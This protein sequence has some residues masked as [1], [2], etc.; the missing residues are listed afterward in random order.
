[1]NRN[2]LLRWM[3]AAC[4]TL[5][6][7]GA[8]ASLTYTCDSTIDA[9][10]AGT[11]AAL[12][13]SI[14]GLYNSTFTNANASIYIQYGTTGLGSSTSGFLNLVS[15]NTYR[16]ALAST[17][18]GNA[19]DTSALA[20]LPGAEPG[21]F[22]G[23]Q[24]Q[25][26]SALGAAL[27]LSGM[28]GT[29]AGGAACFTPG[30]GGCYNGII[31]ITNPADL[32]ANFGQSLYYRD[33]AFSP[34]AYDFYSVVEHET[35]EVLGSSSCIDT[36]GPS[37]SDGCGGSNAGAVDLFRYNAGARVFA[38][39]TPGA[40]FS[41]NGGLSTVETYNTLSNGNDYAD[42][43]TNCAHVQDASGCLGQGF[44]ITNDGGVELSILDA[45]GFNLAA[46]VL[47]IP[48]PESLALFG[49]GIVALAVAR[50]RR[51]Q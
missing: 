15:Y 51:K 35:D 17:A 22:A 12:N 23:G 16:A 48:E 11:C 27:G 25:V 29:T 30:S 44:D 39:T 4:A 19:T 20:S 14:S 34:N 1:M 36:Q 42:F 5:A 43:I 46:Q 10:H 18:S 40:G 8:F 7:S 32:L 6:S 26:T 31:T 47:A 13:S 2:T 45:I 50:R 24:I 49:L 28:V 41:V 33:S 21:I 9:R 37:L 38:D 3:F